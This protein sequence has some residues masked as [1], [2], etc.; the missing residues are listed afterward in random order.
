[1]PNTCVLSQIVR[2]VFPIFDFKLRAEIYRRN[3]TDELLGEAESAPSDGGPPRAYPLA[4]GVPSAPGEA[5]ERAALEAERASDHGQP[6]TLK[7]VQARCKRCSKFRISSE[8]GQ[9]DPHTTA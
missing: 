8:T 6:T 4:L 1:M 2:F 7:G 5:R 9:Y 3:E